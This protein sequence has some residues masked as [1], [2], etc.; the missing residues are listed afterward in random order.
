MRLFRR[1]YGASPLHL[2]VL[3][4][5]FCVGGYAASRIYVSS[6]AWLAILVWFACS[7]LGHDLI[8]WPA[9]TVV[10]AVTAR[11]PGTR[12]SSVR[13]V[14]WINYVRVPVGLSLLLLLVYFPLVLGYAGSEY[15]G[16]TG[17]ALSVY[18]G[19]WFAICAVL[20]AGSAT[21][22]AGRLLAAR[23]ADPSPAAKTADRPADKV[24]ADRRAD[25]AAADGVA[26]DD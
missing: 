10:D 4:V 23:R 16:T 7:V 26:A 12:T 11:L 5:G 22:Y 15:E 13:A 21:W 14:P 19:R 24:A 20:F 2:L 8:F 3:V 6:S 17:L 1:W 9:Y 25:K 18:L